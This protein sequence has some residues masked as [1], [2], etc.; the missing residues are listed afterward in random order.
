MAKGWGAAR[1]GLRCPGFSMVFIAK[2]NEFQIRIVKEE[3]NI[4]K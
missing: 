4:S 1:W 2:H 3:L